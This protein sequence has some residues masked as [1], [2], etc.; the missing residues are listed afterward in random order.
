MKMNIELKKWRSAL[1]LI[2]LL[3]PCAGAQEPVR[4]AQQLKAEAQAHLD[5]FPHKN[6]LEAS[7]FRGTIVF[8]NYCINC[9]GVNADGMG[10]AA[11]LY[12]PK[13]SNL[14]TSMMTDLYND[15]IIRRGGKAMARSEFMPPWGEELTEEQ[16]GD[17]VRYLRMIAPLGPPNQ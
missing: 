4:N 2:C 11:R 6:T 7:V 12:D 5:A 1:V 14:R 8:L 13:P 17:V 9:H 3:I 10:R 16:L 15:S